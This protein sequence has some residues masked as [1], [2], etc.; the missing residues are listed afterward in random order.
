MEVTINGPYKMHEF[1][2][3]VIA[4]LKNKRWMRNI[5]QNNLPRYEQFDTLGERMAIEIYRF[6]EMAKNNVFLSQGSGPTHINWN[7]V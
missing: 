4:V 3:K 5:K 2:S 7:G 1:H 6:V